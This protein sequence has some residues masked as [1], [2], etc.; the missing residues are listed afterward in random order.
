VVL[1]VGSTIL[2]T[3]LR[4][5]HIKHRLHVGG[6]DHRQQMTDLV[7]IHLR[8]PEVEDRL[9]SEHWENDLGKGTFNRSAVGTFVEFV[10]RLV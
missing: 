5:T 6:V 9:L 10:S 4:Q 2:I 1:T 7:S 3:C 8:L